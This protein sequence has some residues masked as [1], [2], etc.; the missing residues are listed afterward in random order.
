MTKISWP[1]L[2]PVVDYVPLIVFFALYWLLDLYAATAGLMLAV[3]IGLILS[4]ALERTVPTMPLVTAGLVIVFGG[5]TLALNDERFIKMKPTI[6]QG[7][8]SAILLGSLLIRRPI[9]KNFFGTAW[10]LTD[11]GWQKLTLRLGLFFAAAGVLNEI[12]W[13]TQ[14]T[15]FWVNFK[16]FGLIGITMLFMISQIPLINRYRLA[17]DNP[18]EPSKSPH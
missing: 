13:R 7:L 4:Y 2:K 3:T 16:V 18:S 17:E 6:V 12:V 9:L 8:F 15:D 14:S 11:Q 5:L 10:Q 1:W